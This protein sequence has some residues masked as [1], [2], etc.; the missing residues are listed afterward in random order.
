MT[1][2]GKRL[3]SHFSPKVKKT[4][5]IFSAMIA[6]EDGTGAIEKM[7]AYGD[8][9]ADVYTKT[10][11]VYNLDNDMFDQAMGVL[12]HFKRFYN[13]SDESFKKRNKSVF[14]RAYDETFGTVWNMKH[15]FE[16]YF[17]TAKTYIVDNIG[18]WT[19]NLLIN[20][21]F[22]SLVP[23]EVAAW[24]LENA[25][26]SPDG[27]FSGQKGIKFYNNGTVKQSADIQS[28]WY[29]VTLAIKGSG[30]LEVIGADGDKKKLFKIG[31]KYQEGSGSKRNINTRDWDFVQFFFYSESADN[32]TIIV[33]GEDETLADIVTLDKK[34]N[35]P[36]FVVYVWFESVTV[37]SN[38]LH[39]STDGNDP[40]EGI[41]YEKE[42][43]YN[44]AF[45]IGVSGKSFAEDVYNDILGLVKAAGTKGELMLITKES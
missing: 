41:D 21:N 23:E 38:T 2:F 40:I 25:E 17:P 12:S 6:N 44:N 7:F 36:C 3:W 5:E 32:V 10:D 34:E 28:G 39:L 35:Y 26:I 45:Y 19:N 14:I 29:F 27:A 43:Y 9:V 20:S 13:E 24:E 8:Q 4:G 15:V 37:G 16:Y 18:K 22:E 31:E 33:H 42:S 11:N 30:G 1:D